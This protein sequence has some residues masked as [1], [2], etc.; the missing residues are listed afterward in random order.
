MLLFQ[1]LEPPPPFKNPSDLSSII[2][3][4]FQLMCQEIL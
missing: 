3:A 2:I 1:V 4:Q